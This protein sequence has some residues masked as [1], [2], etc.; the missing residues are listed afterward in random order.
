MVCFLLW[1]GHTR[2]RFLY[3]G[4]SK[5]VNPV[6][7]KIIGNIKGEP[8]CSSPVVVV[9]KETMMASE[10]YYPHVHR[11]PKAMADL[12][13]CAYSMI[14]F[15]GVRVPFDLCVEAEAFGS[16]I[17]IG[18]KRSGPILTQ[19]AFREKGELTIPPDIFHKGRFRVI[20]DSIRILKHKTEGEITVYAGAVG[21]L[22]LLGSLYGENRIRTWLEEEPNLMGRN[23]EKAADF[24]KDY[25]EQI[26]EA[27]ADVLVLLEPA[28]SDNRLGRTCFS[29]HLLSTYQELRRRIQA[30]IILHI[31]GSTKGILDLID[32]TGFEAYSF[33]GPYT[34]VREARSKIRQKTLLVGNIATFDTLLF[35][36]PEEV[37]EESINALEEGI[38]ILSP[39]CGVPIQTP[40]QN[41]KTMVRA[42]EEFN[43]GTGRR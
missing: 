26:F 8:V 38:D 3:T 14:G 28:A 16:K 11:D 33:E 15:K 20:L 32:L 12:A 29:S 2:R 35:G 24:L 43:K 27:G 41:L 21:P 17:R 7:S 1:R 9:T 25:A 39:G 10:C 18:N 30:P 36:T 40:I 22:S 23:L 42:A 31:C 13:Y 19:P 4:G 37:Y 34:S 5:E 6:L